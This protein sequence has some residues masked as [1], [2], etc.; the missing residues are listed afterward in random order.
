MNPL[1]GAMSSLESSPSVPSLSVTLRA[2]E[3]PS[4][5]GSLDRASRRQAGRP[6]PQ[7]DD[8][9]SAIVIGAGLGG[10]SAAIHLARRGWRVDIL[11]RND[12]SGGRMDLIEQNG[13]RIDMG[14]SML[15]MP[16]VVEQIF[17]ACERDMRDY[18]TLQRVSPAYRVCWPDGACLDMGT[19][20]AEMEAAVRRFAPADAANF[21]RLIA[22]M[23]AKY[24]NARYNFIER[25]FN[26]VSSLLRPSTLNGLIKSLPLESVAQFVNR[27]LTNKRLREAFTFQTL[28][29]GIS[30]YDC[31]AI[32]ALLPYIEMEFGVWFPKG[33]MY[34]IAQ[35][36]ERLFLELGGTIHYNQPVERILLRGR[37]AVGV[38]SADGT[39]RHSDVVVCNMDL[40]TAYRRLLP[41]DAR[42]KHTDTALE[43]RD[44]G[45]SGYLLYLGIRHIP[46]DWGHNVIVLSDDYEQTLDDICR[47]K[48]SPRDP[49]LHV[50]IPTRTDP[51]LAPRGHDIVYVLVPVPNTQAAIDWKREAPI[52]RERVLDK[53]EATGLPGLRKN[54]VFERAFT[55]PEYTE[56][57]G[58][59]AGAAFGGLTPTFAQSGY[60]RPHNRSEDIRD[61]YFVG[62]ST[63]PG[64]GMPI[65][66]TSG[67]LAAEEIAATFRK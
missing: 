3:K 46:S 22:G 21:S 56:R 39:D 30:P 50:C 6:S 51:S 31:P 36:L 5:R 49:A 53:L 65:V 63:H 41:A 15:M 43:R 4:E 34:S 45:C 64:G 37:Q 33:G 32:Y 20:F 26:T 58:C 11:E 66:L 18:L 61:L 28:Y 19:P 38:R 25:R 1:E 48:I 62:A 10:L 12:R 35:A 16:E 55:P 42:R 14:P 9:P 7:Q 44:Y 2:P 17:A 59:Y 60:F 47:K 23:R 29:L 40:P 57:Y 54:L 8:R 13:F 24:Q 27:T 67:R 52:L